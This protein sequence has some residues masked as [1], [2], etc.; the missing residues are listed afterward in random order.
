MVVDG[1]GEVDEFEMYLEAD[2]TELA[3]G[4]FGEGSETEGH[5]QSNSQIF[6]SS[7]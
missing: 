4:L 5:I 2:L 6:V 3:N 7:N 1:G